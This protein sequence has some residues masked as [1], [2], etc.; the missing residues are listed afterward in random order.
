LG[1]E[2]SYLDLGRDK[3]RFDAS[4]TGSPILARPFFNV[5]TEQQDSQ[6]FAFPS[7]RQGSFSSL[8][9]SEFQVVEALV[10]RDL[11]RGADYRIDLLA[12]YRYQR[13]DDSLTVT[14]SFVQTGEGSLPTGTNIAIFDEFKTR[15]EFNGGELG[16][17]AQWRR[18]RWTFD[19]TMKLGLG[20]THSRV[21]ING[22]TTKTSSGQTS[23]LEAGGL[24]ALPSN[25]GIHESDRLSVAPELGLNLGYDL[26]C[27][28]RLNFGYTFM[29]WSG[30]ARPG[31]QIDLNIDP[32]QF[33]P[34]TVSNATQP[35]FR[36]RTTDYWAQGI[37]LGLDYRF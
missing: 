31:D 22:S 26:T 20:N 11:C 23:T 2:F 14:D 9:V 37:N 3:D 5:E 12:G 28:L 6:L 35:E 30:V 27:R 15:N 16:F 19:G 33:P 21:G 4:S 18:S 7:L 34:P 32:R 10:R 36:L 13:L 8:S 24:L 17:A 1:I 29:F 25:M